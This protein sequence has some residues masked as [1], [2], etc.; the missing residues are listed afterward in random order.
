M[1]K[2]VRSKSFIPLEMASRNARFLTGFTMIE[3]LIVVTIVGILATIGITQYFPVREKSLGKEAIANLKLIGAAERI[4]RM[5][6]GQFGAC[7]CD[8]V[9]TGANCCNNSTDG[10]NF[11][12]K[13]N[14][15]PTYWTYQVVSTTAPATFTV[16][17]NRSG[18]GGYLDCQYRFSDT[19]GEPTV[20]GGL[21]P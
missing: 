4:Y 15:T 12:L 16:T 6:R 20:G 18:S 3:L 14:L 17:A 1:K 2:K 11:F 19:D 13:L 21:C 7:K 5:E 9:G 8:C 10:C